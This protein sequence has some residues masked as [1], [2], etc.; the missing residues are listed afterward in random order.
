[1]E[2]ATGLF[3]PILAVESAALE[4]PERFKREDDGMERTEAEGLEEVGVWACCVSRMWFCS[5]GEAIAWELRARVESR[6]EQCCMHACALPVDR[7]GDAAD[8]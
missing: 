3:L 5:G 7:L 4:D 2:E 8:R 6:D 1:M